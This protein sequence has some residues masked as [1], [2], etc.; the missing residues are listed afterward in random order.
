M[1]RLCWMV[2]LLLV[3]VGCSQQPAKQATGV[4]VATGS[5]KESLL[6][7]RRNFKTKLVK[8]AA[9][10]EPVEEPPATLF[11]VV[12]Y[13]APGGKYPAYL[14]P[15]AKDGKKR[16]A[17]I[18]ITGG[19]CNTIGN[20]WHDGPPDNDQ[21]ASAFRKAGIIMMF[22]SLRGGNENPGAQEGFLGEV[23]DVI[24]AAEFLAKQDSVDPQRIYLGGH[25]TGGTLVM[26][27]AA[28][29]DRFRGVFSFGPVEDL[30]GYSPEYTPFD[31]SNPKEF[32]MRS[33][34][35][36][37]PSIQSPTFVFEGTNQ[38]GNLSSLQ[39]LQR[40]S[41]NPKVYFHPVKG[42]NHFSILRPVTKLVADKV[43]GDEGPTTSIRFTDQELSAAVK[44]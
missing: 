5:G 34:K 32:E 7:A 18:W 31:R 6:E 16:P 4:G 11:R 2:I 25:S 10:R 13:D 28:A 9:Q 42:V 12:H 40:A 23:D 29:S 15:A 33:P 27:V 1:K 38:P 24:A 44:R 17:I 14:S 8:R 3:A 19:D 35:R 36:W 41:T 26:L 39:A 20:V 37:L 30:A 43:L 22:P 21:T